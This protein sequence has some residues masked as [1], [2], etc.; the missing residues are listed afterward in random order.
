MLKGQS[1]ISLTT[2]QACLI[3]LESN[4][5]WNKLQLN[6]HNGKK[7]FNSV[8]IKIKNYNEAINERVKAKVKGKKSILEK[9]QPL[10]DS[11]R[12]TT[13][14]VSFDKGVNFGNRL[15]SSKTSSFKDLAV[16]PS[17]IDTTVDECSN[18]FVS[19]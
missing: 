16:P 12:P 8:N 7:L 3:P 19:F 5:Q 18:Y 10:N 17:S 9:A 6:H 13:M 11:K 2:S 1:G 4:L 14:I 15:K